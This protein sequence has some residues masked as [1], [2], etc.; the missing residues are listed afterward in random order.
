MPISEL[1]TSGPVTINSTT[2]VQA[3]SMSIDPQFE[4]ILASAAGE[5]VPSFAAI[6]STK[7]MITY[8][9]T[10]VG[11]LLGAVSPLVGLCI[12]T[13]TVV[14]YFTRKKKCS[15][16]SADGDH[17]TV[18]LAAGLVV[19]NRV[20]C[21]V[22]GGTATVEFSIYAAEDGTNPVLA[23]SESASLPA[24][25]NIQQLFTLGIQKIN[26]TQLPDVQNL[27]IDFQPQVGQVMGSQDTAP[28]M[29]TL[30]TVSPR[31]TLET[32]N[33]V[34]L[35][36]F[37]IAGTSQGASESAFYLQRLS[38]GAGRVAA[39]TSQHVK[40][41]LAANQGQIM[42]GPAAASGRNNATCQVVVQPISGTSAIL[43]IATAS[44]MS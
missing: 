32:L 11:T 10:Q 24:N 22:S 25:I 9:T 36:D 15:P 13:G 19:I 35:S 26:G 28:S 3:E 16:V 34:Y 12:P 29:I 40:F 33:P 44:A 31:I 1:F 27:S 23:F 30:D 41:S 5:P 14:M 4:Q 7:P 18:T 37:T 42:A 17:F 20:S 2:I 38:K 21:P 43:T 6:I 39:G 8:T